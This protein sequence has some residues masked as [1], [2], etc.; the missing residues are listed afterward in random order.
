MRR[1]LTALPELPQQRYV[2]NP[3]RGAL[4]I[5]IPVARTNLLTNGSFETNTT[6]WTASGGSI[7]RS[8]TQQYHGA[9]SLAVTPTAGT[10]DGVFY[11]TVS[12]I[13]G[14]T[15]AAS[16]KVYGAPGVK[17]KLSIATTGGV[18]LAVYRFVGIG[19]WQWVWVYW[20][21]T[22]STTR[23]IYI[24]KDTHTSTAVFY[25]DGAQ[26]EAIT[27]GETVS[28]YLDGD[29]TSLLRQGQFPPAYGWNGVRH[30]ST[31]YRSAMTRD[32]GM[33]KNFDLFKLFLTGLT[34]LGLVTP[35]HLVAPQT[36]SDGDTYQ[37]SVVPRREFT[38]QARLNTHSPIA[39]DLAL[40]ALGSA[41]R[42]DATAPRQP[43]AL[44]YQRH[45]GL[46]PMGDT[47][48][49]IAS[50]KEGLGGNQA[51]IVGDDIDAPF[52]Q[53][54]PFIVSHDGGTAMTQ[55]ESLSTSAVS[56]LLYRD[57]N[58]D[59]SN[60]SQHAVTDAIRDIA[61]NPVDR[62]YYITGNF[63]TI[64]GV[65]AVDIATYDPATGTFAALG[66]GLLGTG[67]RRLFVA[68]DG[69]VYVGGT[70]TTANGVTVNNITYWD[71]STFVALGSGG[72]KG[73]DDNVN[74]ITMDAA[75]NLYVTGNFLNAGG[76][77]AVRIAML[78]PAG[79]WSALGTGLTGGTA[80]GFGLATGLDGTSI[81]VT[82]NFDTANGVTVNFVAKWN[83]TTFEALGSGLDSG[84]LDI[85]TA[86]NGDIYVSGDFAGAS[87]VTVNDIA[88]WNGSGWS[89]LGSG[90]DGTSANRI[91]F[92]AD[93]LMYIGGVFT[94]ISGITT[95]DSFAAWNGSAWIVP[96]V[97]S[98]GTADASAIASGPRGELMVFLF[99]GTASDG[100]AAQVNTLT[101]TGSARTYPTI[102][103]VGPSSSTSS[104][105]QLRSY[106]TG[107]IVSFNLTIFANEV[108]TITTGPDII[109]VASNTRGDL[110]G[111]V[112]P[113]SAPGLPLLPGV[114]SV[115]LFVTGGTVTTTAVWPRQFQ[116]VEDLTYA[117]P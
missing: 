45:E 35:T 113:G 29:Q 106:T 74:G 79:A 69:R 15:Y 14:T 70:F 2:L 26:V 52:L 63:A 62:K 90:I 46:T 50:Y 114:N 91:T 31:S 6:N 72:T 16:C 43:V 11:G 89:A 108:I 77:G 105:V 23:R 78:S 49:I 100:V 37:T 73:V 93:G 54:L 94:G 17:Y 81:Y 10:T 104:L 32:G 53:W 4:S 57:T 71:G 1:V 42:M 5:I 101:N 48:K 21:E 110:S 65:A 109:G 44:L 116:A 96:D 99:D 80:F 38:I 40:R 51:P 18:D 8:T 112:L 27:A 67:G 22:S 84:G 55:N 24:T 30:A 58:G 76:A 56:N 92:A 103:I 107:A 98:A 33:V 102:T 83:G 34:G 39:R 85:K 82:G 13:S 117:A 111:S 60:L 86:P 47:G 25:I 115:A 64:G 19:R 36:Y 20:T 88:R 7:A 12:L 41:L 97:D 87:G 61:F 59:W 95:T 68:P 75:G 9:Y 66:T 28:T 3:Q